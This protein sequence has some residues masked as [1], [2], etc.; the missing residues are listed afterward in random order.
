MSEKRDVLVLMSGG[1]DSATLVWEFSTQFHRVIPLYVRFGFTWEKAEIYWLR[2]YLRKLASR[3]IAPLK[4]IA[5]PVGDVYP[6]HWSMTGKETPGFDTDDDAV[7]LP[8][9]N[10]LLL[11]KA[12]VHASL[13]GVS[14]IA[15]GI[16]KGNPFPDSTPHFLRTLEIAFSEGL[17]TPLTILTP[18]IT[19]TKKDVLGRGRSLPLHL[20]FS[21]IAP[22]GHTH[23]GGCNKCAERMRAFQSVRLPDLTRYQVNKNGT[24]KL[25]MASKNNNEK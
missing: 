20:T 24:R 11:S 15:S 12:A 13:Q 6:P 18:Y 2:R 9:R 23:C 16:L 21:C 14:L 17:R 5:M 25:N 3:S 10:I 22:K 1:I 19:L 4:I 8:G 7:Y